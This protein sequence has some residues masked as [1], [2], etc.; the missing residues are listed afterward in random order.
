MPEG[1]TV[2]ATTIVSGHEAQGPAALIRLKDGQ[3]VLRLTDFHIAP[4]APDVHVFLTGKDGDVHADGVFDFGEVD[5]FDGDFEYSLPA[6]VDL[7]SHNL[8]VVYCFQYS[9]EF[10]RGTLN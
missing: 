1:E 5:K 8:V 2:I 6:D 4:G 3:V 9:V 10:G 7:A